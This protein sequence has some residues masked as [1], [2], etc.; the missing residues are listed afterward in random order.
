M[1]VFEVDGRRARAQRQGAGRP[2]VYLHSGFGEVGALPLFDELACVVFDVRRVLDVLD[3]ERAT[4]V[5][6]SLG[7]WLATELAVW[8]PE[9][10]E[11]FVLHD[12]LGLRIEG[13]PV[14]DVFGSSQHDVWARALPHGGDLIRHLAPAVDGDDDPDA[15][16]LHLFH[17]LETT[18]RIGWNPYLHDPKLLARLPLIGAPTLVLWGAD[19]GIVPL[20]HGEAYAAGIPGAR[21]AVLHSCGHLP[22][23]ERPAEL[24][25]VVAAFVL[26]EAS[27]A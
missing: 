23:L 27:V 16:R 8:F 14:Y 25:A 21:L 3:V 6:S 22:A 20:A 1:D 7:G 10:V 15:V 5:G 19:D 18:A 13:A 2:L 11:A 17:A 9:R 26:K 24:A 4:F 12:A